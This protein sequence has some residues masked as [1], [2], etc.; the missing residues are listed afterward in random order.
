M[1]AQ[2][3]HQRAQAEERAERESKLGGRA[4]ARSIGGVDTGGAEHECW[5]AEWSE[6]R[7]KRVPVAGDVIAP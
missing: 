2:H 5:G 3:R 1:A 6:T 7:K 4:G